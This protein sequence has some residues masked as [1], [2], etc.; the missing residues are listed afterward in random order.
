VKPL[1]L[2]LFRRTRPPIATTPRVR[3]LLAAGAPV[4][5][6]VSGG[7]DS[8]AVA[9]ATVDYLDS[10]AHAGPRVLVHSDLGVTEWP[11]SLPWC[12]KLADRLGLELVVVRRTKG[13]MMDRWEQRWTDNL[14][15]YVSLQCVQLILPWSTP[16]MRF[17]TSELKTDVICRALSRRFEGETILNVT[18][19]RREESSDRACAPIAAMQ[20]KLASKTRRTRGVEWHPIPDWTLAET[21]GYLEEKDFPL[22]PAYIEW[23]LTRVSC[24]YCIM[25]SIADLRAATKCPQTHDLF[26]RMV[27][28]EIRST[29]GFH[30]DLWLGDVAPQLLSEGEREQLIAAK[31]K[32]EARRALESLIPKD[33]LYVKG[34]PTC[35]PTRE[36]AELLCGVRR[37]IGQIIGVDVDYVDPAK[38][39]ARYE[40]LWAHRRRKAA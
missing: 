21:L 7:K 2:P 13:D 38:L 4:A 20:P 40:S 35:I 12:R 16:K 15:R 26:R 3:R 28:L 33:L 39:I 19:I 32:A 6:G 22:H 1:E 17:C 5:I 8:S 34:W 18:G 23:L 29:F 9:L 14:A 11:W 31:A 25:S 36:S 24:V 10:I 27:R 37:Q 30:G